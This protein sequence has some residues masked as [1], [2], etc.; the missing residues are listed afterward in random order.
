MNLHL[1]IL[2]TA[3]WSMPVTRVPFTCATSKCT[4]TGSILLAN[5]FWS[6]DIQ[7]VN[8]NGWMDCTENLRRAG[9]QGQDTIGSGFKAGCTTAIKWYMQLLKFRLCEHLA[10]DNQL[11]RWANLWRNWLRIQSCACNVVCQDWL[12]Q[13][14]LMN[15]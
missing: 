5:S 6:F 15:I 9:V 1:I 8:S 12:Q 7:T 3:S 2:T 13:I 14:N 4:D 11:V 10:Y